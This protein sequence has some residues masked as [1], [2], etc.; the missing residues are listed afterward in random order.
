[1]LV[2]FGISNSEQVKSVSKFADG[3]VVG[4]A[5]LDAVGEASEGYVLETA[6]TFIKDLIA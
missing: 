4:S 2:G 6:S 1:M 5:L 3:V